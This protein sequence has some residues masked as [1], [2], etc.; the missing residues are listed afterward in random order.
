MTKIE[1]PKQHDLEDLDLIKHPGLFA[2]CAAK[3]E[4]VAA[5]AKKK[6]EYLNPKSETISND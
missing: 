5:R 3:K 6:S 1:N 4:A 2:D